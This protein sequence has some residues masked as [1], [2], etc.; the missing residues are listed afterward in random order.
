MNF[1]LHNKLGLILG[2][3]NRSS[4]RV[5]R[6]VKGGTADLPLL[7]ELPIGEA[8]NLA[9]FLSRNG[10]DLDLRPI[11]YHSDWGVRFVW[12]S[13]EGGVNSRD[14]YDF[15][16]SVEGFMVWE[17]DIAPSPTAQ[18]LPRFPGKAYFY[19]KRDLSRF[20]DDLVDKEF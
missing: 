12:K 15:F 20:L 1:Q 3:A 17:R 19:T 18:K 11:D 6:G 8:R 9:V 5:F 10:E 16:R 7:V 14:V 4:P 2:S 13:G